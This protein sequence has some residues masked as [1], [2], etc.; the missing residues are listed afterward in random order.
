MSTNILKRPNKKAQL[1]RNGYDLGRRRA[2]TS[3][4]GMLLPVFTN[5]AY[6]G[7]KVR[8]NSSTFIRTEALETAAFIRLRHHV[9]WFFVPIFN[10]YQFWNEFYNMTDDVHT[11]FGVADSSG[12]RDLY[13]IPT[14]ELG[15]TVFGAKIVNPPADPF[16]YSYSEREGVTLKTD[17]FGVAKYWNARRLADMFGYGSPDR[18]WF[19]VD[20]TVSRLRIHPFNYLAYHAVW[21]SHY[22]NS[23]FFKNDPVMYNCDRLFGLTYDSGQVTDSNVALRDR[24]ISTIHYRPF[25]RDF[26]TNIQPAPSFNPSWINYL[27]FSNT[28]LYSSTLK[29]SIS[30]EAAGEFEEFPNLGNSEGTFPYISS[31]LELGKEEGNG[32]SGLSISDIRSLYALDKLFRVAGSTGSHYDQQTLA[33]LGYKVPQGISKEPYFL[34]SQSFDII[35]NEVVAT[36][37]TADKSGSVSGTGT[38]IGDIAG[39][40]FGSTGKEEDI[41]FTAPC[42]GIFIALSSIEPLCDYGS[43]GCELQNRYVNTFDFWRPELDNVGM[44]PV[45]DPYFTGVLPQL[46]SSYV[47]GWTYRWEEL[48]A[49]FDV[50]NEGFWNTSK[51]SWVAIKQD[52]LYDS[53]TQI[54]NLHKLF[55]IRPQYTDNIFAQSFQGSPKPFF[56]ESAGEDELSLSLWRNSNNFASKIYEGDNFLINM[57]IKFYKTSPMSVHSLPTI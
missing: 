38:A 49:S 30:P 56:L 9:D 57:D 29:G 27:G 14:L 25:R 48:K 26:F 39:K 24:I 3:P 43:Y 50:V 31:F 12:F 54:S 19:K 41:E 2:F 16:F 21:Y 17:E 35:I 33:H 53:S 52:Q 4:V 44:Q 40:A 20:N 51:R 13:N 6:S 42:E 32:S 18:S 5:F 47:N 36:A 7:E 55:F 22:N 46:E 10:L 28:S 15:E 11:S 34:G 37:T 8:V 1:G 45:F 23:Q